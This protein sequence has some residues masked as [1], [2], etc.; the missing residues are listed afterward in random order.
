MTTSHTYK[1]LTLC[2]SLIFFSPVYADALVKHVFNNNTD[3]DCYVLLHQTSAFPIDDCLGVVAAQS[4]K[5][6]EGSL[7]FSQNNTQPKQIEHRYNLVCTLKKEY[8]S[9]SFDI[10]KQHMFSLNPNSQYIEMTWNFN[11]TTLHGYEMIAVEVSE[12]DL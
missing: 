7:Y 3:Y 5:T 2:L 8:L 1:Y 11:P 4:S 6:C 12:Q 9:K 10:S